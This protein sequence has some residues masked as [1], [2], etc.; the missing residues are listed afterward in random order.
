MSTALLGAAAPGALGAAAPATTAGQTQLVVAAVVGV[1]VIVLL[2]TWAKVHPFLSLV[3]G[4]AALALVAGTPLADTF[5]AFTKGLGSTIGSTG[6]LIALGALIG[7]LLTDSG[8]ADAIVDTVLARTSERKLPWA[9][10]LIAFTVG[11]PL[12]FEVG[13]VLLIPVVMLVARRSQAPLIRVGI[14]ALAGLSVLHA[15]VPPHPGPLTAADY[16]GANIGLTLGL[17]LLVAVPTVIV[18]GPVLANRMARMVP[19]HA[20]AVDPAAAS[21]ERAPRRPGFA[22]TLATVLTPVVLMLLGSLAELFVPEG[23][24]RDALEFFGSSLVALLVAALLSLFTFGLGAGRD[25][26]GVRTQVERSFGPIAAILLIV[27]AGGGFKQTLVDSGVADVIAAGVNGL[28]VSPLLA[29]W[30]IAV[31]VRLATGSATV[32]TVTAAG[33]MVPIAG[34]LSPT[35]DALLVLAVGAG[36]VFLSHVN[37]AGFWLIKEYFGMT[38]GQTLRTWSLMECVLSVVA[39][40]CVMLL[41]LVL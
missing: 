32:A 22:T 36:S 38:I 15:L 35:H 13:V 6:V 25:P 29:G 18:S 23:R 10:A 31:C 21:E 26:A 24:L 11:I 39:L 2:I 40:A 41:S 7:K 5:T 28:P 34:G 19:I 20:P 14:P 16:L 33:I 3:L 8:G 30:V 9:M 27:G 4:S 17:G 37:D 12:F 1:A